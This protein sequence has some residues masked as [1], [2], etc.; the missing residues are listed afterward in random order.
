M[1]RARHDVLLGLVRDGAALSDAELR[2]LIFTPGFSTAQEVSRISGR[3][4]GMDVVR[5]EI[6]RSAGA[7]TIVSQP[8]K[9]HTF[10]LHLPLTLAVAQVVLVAPAA[11]CALPAALVEQVQQVKAKAADRRNTRAA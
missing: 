1:T 10:T 5:N 4:I 11:M 3:G 8:G 6:T 2:E 7:S 9:R